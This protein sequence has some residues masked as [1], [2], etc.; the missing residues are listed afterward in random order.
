[1][2]DKREWEM[3]LD[4]FTDK[5]LE[6]ELARRKAAKTPPSLLDDPEPYRLELIRGMAINYIGHVAIN[7]IDR[8]LAV[9]EERIVAMVIEYFY[10]V[11][12]WDWIQ[13]ATGEEST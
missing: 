1:M 6:V 4:D 7:G 11:N 12:V 2:S 10:G 8:G 3:T 5:E 9:V 13:R